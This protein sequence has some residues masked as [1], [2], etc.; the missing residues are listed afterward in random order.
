MVFPQGI[1]KEKPSNFL[2]IEEQQDILSLS[3]SSAA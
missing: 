2:N 3:E 1:L